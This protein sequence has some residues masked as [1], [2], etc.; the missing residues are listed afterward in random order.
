MKGIIFNLLEDVVTQH[1]GESTWDALL[2]H[3]QLEGAYSSLATY[4]DQELMSLVG[5]ASALLGMPADDVVRWF[6][7]EAIPLLAERFPI[8]FEEHQS[9]STL[10]LTLNDIIHAEVRKLYPD[11]ELPY[12]AISVPE[13]GVVTL[14]YTSPRRLCSLAEGFIEG[15]AKHF[16]EEVQ[17]QQATCLKRGDDTCMLICNFSKQS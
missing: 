15:A 7:K 13:E 6:G 1:K 16:N 14:G 17:V 12:F 11:A 4:P 10:L 9:T 3:A 2:E 8:F 5:S